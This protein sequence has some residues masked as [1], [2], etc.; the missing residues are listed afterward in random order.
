M[1]KDEETPHM[2]GEERLCRPNCTGTSETPPRTWG[3]HQHIVFSSL[4]KHQ[5]YDNCT[6]QGF[7]FSINIHQTKKYVPISPP[8]TCC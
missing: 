6:P 8:S 4:L 2:R 5:I 3:R 7:R 1:M